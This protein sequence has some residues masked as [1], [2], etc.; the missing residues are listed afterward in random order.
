[1]L[2]EREV[3]ELALGK[4]MPSPLPSAACDSSNGACRAHD[5]TQTY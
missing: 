3:K 5:Q 2:G 4:S 1:M